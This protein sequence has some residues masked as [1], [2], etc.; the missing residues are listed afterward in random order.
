MNLT[1]KQ[2]E[3]LTL[4]DAGNADGSKL[5]LDQ[6]LER[7]SYKPTK[8]AIQFTIR[9]LIGHE[10]IEKCG[11]EVRRDRMRVIL[12][13]TALGRHYAKALKPSLARVLVE[14]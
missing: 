6:L 12:G 11:Q 14:D 3:V 10:L 7:L 5:D 4:L 13:P 8:A 2:Q 1:Q 9:A